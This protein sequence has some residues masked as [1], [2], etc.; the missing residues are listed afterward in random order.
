MPDF[1]V[2][3]GKNI[4][5]IFRSDG[6]R[7]RNKYGI[8]SIFP[9]GEMAL[10]G[11]KKNQL[12]KLDFIES[13][14]IKGTLNSRNSSELTYIAIFF[15]SVAHYKSR[16]CLLHHHMKLVILG[17]AQILFYLYRIMGFF[18]GRTE[19]RHAQQQGSL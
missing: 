10:G 5:L 8:I 9:Y 16:M 3:K 14:G 13:P 18:K 2:D 11:K 1:I 12:Y 19:E 17:S 7:I 6:S 15:S 4:S